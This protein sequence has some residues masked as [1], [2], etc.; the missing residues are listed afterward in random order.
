MGKKMTGV[1]TGWFPNTRR[2]VLRLINPPNYPL[3]K[4]Q[5]LQLAIISMSCLGR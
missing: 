4:Q 3:L 2:L 1:G 5:G